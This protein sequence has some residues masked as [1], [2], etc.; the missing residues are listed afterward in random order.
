M[1]NCSCFFRMNTKYF[2][3]CS[4]RGMYCVFIEDHLNIALHYSKSLMHGI[5]GVYTFSLS[6]FL[7]SS[8][9]TFVSLFL[10]YY[11]TAFIKKGR[12]VNKYKS[13]QSTVR[14]REKQNTNM[15]EK[16]G[17]HIAR[18]FLRLL[19][20]KDQ[21]H[22]WIVLT[23]IVTLLF[24][25]SVTNYKCDDYY[26]AMIQLVVLSSTKKRERKKT[27]MRVRRPKEVKFMLL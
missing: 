15:N 23:Y 17:T 27:P 9:W 6:S 4:V 18:H 16:L 25:G 1:Y 20:R 8:Q 11:T 12:K 7:F 10:Y 5:R 2:T 14:K 19:Q 13:S 22:C 3:S 26:T 21:S 24:G